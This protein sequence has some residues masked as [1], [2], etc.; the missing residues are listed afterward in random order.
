MLK[1]SVGYNSSANAW[2]ENSRKILNLTPKW[3]ELGFYQ[4]YKCIE[5]LII[6]AFKNKYDK[7]GKFE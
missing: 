6:V 3:V 2:S 4:E 5:R 7:S 1:I